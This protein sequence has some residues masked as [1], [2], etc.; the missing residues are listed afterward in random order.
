M[1][2]AVRKKQSWKRCVTTFLVQITNYEH[3]RVSYTKNTC[4]L[5]NST[6]FA[7]SECDRQ[8]DFVPSSCVQVAKH[9]SYE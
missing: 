8:D 3:V 6:R 1:R 2:H 9:F 7:D 4:R 5:D